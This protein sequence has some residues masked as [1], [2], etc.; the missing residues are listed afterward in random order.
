MTALA[1][2]LSAK[3]LHKAAPLLLVLTL[4]AVAGMALCI[5]WLAWG[6]HTLRARVAEISAVSAGNAASLEVCRAGSGAMS[7]GI[8]H[9][10]AAVDRFAGECVAKN[11]AVTG[12][13]AE[14]LSRPA[15]TFPQGAEAMNEW[16]A[17]YSR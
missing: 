3:L 15:R 17:G 7:A 4:S 10:N 8:D 14:I 11:E 2:W 13:V 16:L 9:Q 1:A 6:N 5:G 12:R